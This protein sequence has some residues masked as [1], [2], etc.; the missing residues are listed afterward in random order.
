MWECG[1]KTDTDD[2]WPNSGA[3]HAVQ[4]S[5]SIHGEAQ[6]A[7]QLDARHSVKMQSI[8]VLVQNYFLQISDTCSERARPPT[9]HAQTITE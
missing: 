4:G 7:A 6:S 1:R 3:V 5:K 8:A 2:Q 9:M